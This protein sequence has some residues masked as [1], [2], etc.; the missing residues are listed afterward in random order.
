MIAQVQL[1]AN[2]V[3]LRYATMLTGTDNTPTASRINKGAV[4]SNGVPAHL[5]A[6][7]C[8]HQ[9]QHRCC[10]KACHLPGLANGMADDALQLQRLN[11]PL[12]LV[13]FQQQY[14]QERLW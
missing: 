3:P 1:A 2:T 7:A 13:F 8:N 6:E 11:D 5:C 12:F 14:P 10:H 9:H 4:S